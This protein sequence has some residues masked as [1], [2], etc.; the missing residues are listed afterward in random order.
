MRPMATVIAA[1]YF[2]STPVDAQQGVA[3][4]AVDLRSS[5]PVAAEH[6]ATL[7]TP[8]PP[9]SVVKIATIAAALESGTLGARTT[10]PCT[11]EAS[12][13][14]RR[15]T[16]THPDLLR[17]LTPAEALA[18]SCNVFAATVAARLPRQALDGA[19]ASLGLP[20]TDPRKVVASAALGVDGLLVPPRK[21]LDAVARIAAEPNRIGWK[22]ATLSVVRE[23]LRGAARYG[24]ASA[25][26]ARGIDALAKTG[27]TISGGIE[28]GLVVGV[29]PSVRPRI[30][31]VLLG[32]GIAGIDAAALAAARLV[33][34]QR[35]PATLRIGVARDRGGYA[36]R[37]LPIEEYVSGVLSGEALPESAPAALEALAITIRTYALA[38]RS[39]HASEGFDL[40]DLTH[41]QVL[42]RPTPATDRA[43]ASTAGRAML[44]NGSPAPV[45]YSA[46]CGGHTELPAEV[47]PGET[48]PPYLPSR[49]DDACEGA[50][51]WS[52]DL[53]AS[54]LLRSFRRAGF[55]GDSL[56]ALTVVARNTSGRV[57]AL[58]LD[59]LVPSRVSGQDLRTIVGRTLGWQ[60]LKSTAF[61]LRRSAAGFRFTG[62]GSGHGVGL[63]VIGSARLA[64]RGESA[65]R[66]LERYFPGLAISGN[67]AAGRATGSPTLMVV[68][69]E[70][71]AGERDL[72]QQLA[73]RARDDLERRLDV[74]APQAIVLRFHPTTES[75]RRATG[76]PW[77]T[78]AAAI[79]R[80]IHLVPL[81]VLRQRGTLEATIRHELVH[82]LTEPLLEG[83]PLWIRE[84]AAEYFSRM[85]G[86][87]APA[88]SGSCPTDR[89]LDR[90]ASSDAL[91]AAY[92]RAAACVAARINA[93]AKWSEIR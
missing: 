34:L 73:V 2:L 92:R 41:C 19:L 84:G 4:L 23:G 13:A 68:V 89:E 37:T 83:R 25:L 18:H 61:E 91:G 46:S 48:N 17:P 30:G 49:S 74:R 53:G 6:G 29:T 35:Q 5:A 88:G 63:C 66:I 60:H 55:K 69:P 27:T 8:I 7:D 22:P 47:W 51:A 12:V 79:G 59:G 33:D 57:T 72:V 76:K 71:E 45:F 20:P 14:G 52:A 16:C 9:G 54:D 56:R 38:N 85:R 58:R 31:F 3:F 21:L 10:I 43:A 50:P 44:F 32:A 39:R 64:A 77:F 24:T 62:H 65:E 81:D 36:I 80:E 26:D 70:A 15:L 11:R 67:D 1:L 82:V 93:G 75:Y 87:E 42:R 86:V 40:C 78:S 28:R 90:P